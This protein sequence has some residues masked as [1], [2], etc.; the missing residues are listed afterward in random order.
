MTTAAAAQMSK[1]RGSFVA[2]LFT[3]ATQ[4]ENFGRIDQLI[5]TSE[6]EGLKNA[7]QLPEGRGI[8]ASGVPVRWRRI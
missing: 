1:D 8:A 5:R 6:V 2:S 4:H 3:G 7:A